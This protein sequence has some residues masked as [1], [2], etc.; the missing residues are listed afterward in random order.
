LQNQLE[1]LEDAQREQNEKLS[2]TVTL[3]LTPL[4]NI[5]ML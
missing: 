4:V 5:I 3:I 2:V 1:D